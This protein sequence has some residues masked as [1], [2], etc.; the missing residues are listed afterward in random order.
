MMKLLWIPIVLYLVA[1]GVF[2]T[3]STTRETDEGFAAQLLAGQ[4]LA[5]PIFFFA[6]L[7]IWFFN[8][9]KNSR[10]NN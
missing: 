4:G 1:L 10:K 6:F 9:R 8:H 2:L 3:R 5:L 7:F